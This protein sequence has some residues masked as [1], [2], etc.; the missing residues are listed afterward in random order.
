GPER[1]RAAGEALARIEGDRVVAELDRYVGADDVAGEAAER[2]PLVLEPGDEHPLV[3]HERLRPRR[4]ILKKT[5]R[6]ELPLER[7]RN[8]GAARKELRLLGTHSPPIVSHSSARYSR[9]DHTAV[10]PS[11]TAAVTPRG[12]W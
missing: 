9:A 12:A 3:R 4:E 10:V 2:P 11:Y 6:V 1:P 7:A 8:R 5:L